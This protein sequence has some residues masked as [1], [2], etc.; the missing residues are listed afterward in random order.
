[1]KRYLKSQ[2]HFLSATFICIIILHGREKLE[3]D[4]KKIHTELEAFKKYS[5]ITQI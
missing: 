5:V 3:V 2:W 4:K 1:M